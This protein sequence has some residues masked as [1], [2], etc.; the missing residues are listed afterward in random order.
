MQNN[1]I[2]GPLKTAHRSATQNK[3]AARDPGLKLNKY[4][5]MTST[6]EPLVQI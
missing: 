2:E 4:L 5:Y 1:F 6:P 3:L